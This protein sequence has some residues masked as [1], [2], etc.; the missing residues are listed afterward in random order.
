MGFQEFT[1]QNIFYL[2]VFSFS[3]FSA[4]SIISFIT[5]S[6]KV[7]WFGSTKKEA[8]VERMA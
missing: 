6:Q 3:V 7:V 5:D 8:V 4:H 1:P 2:S